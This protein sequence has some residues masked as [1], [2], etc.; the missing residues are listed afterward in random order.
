[1]WMEQTIVQHPPLTIVSAADEG[2]AAHFAAMLHSAWTHHPTA[3]FYLLDCGIE[4]QT[5]G[6]L[7]EFANN[8]SIRLN[9][10]I[11]DATMFRDLPTTK[12]FSAA[13]YARLLIPDLFPNS[14][15]RVL[16]LDADCIVVDD[17]LPLWNFDMGKAAIA[18]APDF[19]GATVEGE[20]DINSG[21]MLM[22][23]AVWRHEELAATAMTFA[24]KH[25]PR[26]PDQAGINVACIGK[27]VHL[28]EKWNFQLNKPRGPGQWI[29]P[30]IIHYAGPKKPWIYSDVP[31]ASI[32]L[33]HRNQ[34]P[35]VIEPPRTPFRSQWRKTL[36]LLIGR[37]KYWDQLIIS[38]LSQAFATAYFS[39][40][41][42]TAS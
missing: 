18:A 42:R 37:R 3:E 34:T 27:I 17:L 26:L 22:N 33:H 30:S 11:I 5:L 35:F 1:M 40:I 21:V 15:E 41:A 39:R 13:V 25:N 6:A 9:I 8:R 31:F 12:A 10:V 7:R 24:K 23:L 16:Y 38:R 36:N 2:F 32:Y 28:P 4:P 29:E 14:I 19:D 20:I